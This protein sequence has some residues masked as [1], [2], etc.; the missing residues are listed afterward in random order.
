MLCGRMRKTG[1]LRWALRF[2]RSI[3]DVSLS[4]KAA[5]TRVQLHNPSQAG[6]ERR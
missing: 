1:K 3:G 5:V 6:Q 2:D 4:P